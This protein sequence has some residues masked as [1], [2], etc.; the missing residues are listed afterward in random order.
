MGFGVY[1]ADLEEEVTL[2]DKLDISFVYT[3]FYLLKYL[4]SLIFYLNILDIL[5]GLYMVI[6]GSD[7][8]SLQSFY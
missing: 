1:E 5:H 3:I 8:D 6:C 2:M 7:M 4:N